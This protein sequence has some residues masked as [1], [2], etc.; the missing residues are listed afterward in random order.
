M[1]RPIGLAL[2]GCS[3]FFDFNPRI[4]DV[5]QAPAAFLPKAT[6]EKGTDENR[7][8]FWQRAPIR[9][10]PD[11]AAEDVGDGLA[12]KGLLPGEHLV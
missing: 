5:A 4:R 1:L 10:A 11:D 6:P 7:S 8:G 3:G 2:R 12:A 9:L